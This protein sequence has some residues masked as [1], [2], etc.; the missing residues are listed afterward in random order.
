MR[1]ALARSLNR[2]P[3][4]EVLATGG[5]A[6]EAL[7]AVTEVQPDVVVLDLH[8]P[9]NGIEAARRLAVEAPA[10]RTIILSS[11]DDAHQ[12][13]LALAAGA[14]MYLTKD[15]RTAEIRS[16]IRRVH[17][18][19]CDFSPTLALR[20]LGNN[21]LASPWGGLHNECPFEMLEREEQILRRLAQGLGVEEI[22][23]SVGL[24]TAAVEAFLS[25]VLM[26][27]HQSGLRLA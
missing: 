16:A 10:T 2:D 17:A 5:S 14:S 4:L 13:D 18:G 20:L 24:T 12:I 25:N 1:D 27:L 3:Q 8:M 9:G 19:K 23:A 11:D 15:L 22:G 6:A 26:K 7:A 21:P